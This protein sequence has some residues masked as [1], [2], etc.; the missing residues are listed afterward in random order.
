LDAGSLCDEARR[1]TGLT[2][3]GDPAIESRLAILVKNI[4]CESDLH[5]LGRVLTWTH[6]RDLLETR[7]RL[8]QAWKE[9]AGFDTE[10]IERPIFITGMPRSGSTFLQELLTQDAANRAPLVW[11]VMSPLP[12]DARWRM[13]RA[14]TRLWWF[15][16]MAPEADSVHPVRA[17]TPHECV[18]IHSYALL[19][20]E[21]VMKF[22]ISAYERFLNLVDFRPAYVWQKKFLQYLQWRKPTR[23]WILKAPDH[24]FNLEALFQ[25][26]PDAII[27]QTHRNPLEA[28]ESSGRLLEVLQR[29]FAHSRER[30]DIGL[31]EARMLGDGLD[32][33]TRFREGHPELEDRFL[34]VNYDELVAD[35][36]EMIHRLYQKLDM[37]LTSM[38]RE[39]VMHLI[40]KRSRYRPRSGG[41]TLA[42][43]GIDTR[44]V[45]PQFAEYC[46]RFGIR[47]V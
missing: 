27:I 7:L 6:L 22:R 29:V 16:R 45:I 30:C 23:R 40:A 36:A 11:E 33:I 19:S 18:A 14:A 41:P 42:D 39:G 34:D 1:R 43:L 9:S 10:S 3:F 25:I 35:P 15:R 8:E 21:F 2:D 17:A 46:V 24:A 47:Q 44:M 4:E 12:G 13:W 5:L 28:L 37:P 31:H 38:A 26:F 32:R 20:R